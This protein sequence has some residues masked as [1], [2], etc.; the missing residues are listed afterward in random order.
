MWGLATARRGDAIPTGRHGEGGTRGRGDGARQGGL[1][2]KA[3]PRRG[4]GM[5]VAGIGGRGS[6]IRDQFLFLRLASLSRRHCGA[7]PE[8]LRGQIAPSPAVLGLRL[9]AREQ[10][11]AGGGLLG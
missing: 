3:T 8:A 2:G 11:T 5:N 4:R 7:C 1:V 9:K 6:G 10:E